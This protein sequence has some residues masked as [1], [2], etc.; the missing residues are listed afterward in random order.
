MCVCSAALFAGSPCGQTQKLLPPGKPRPQLQLLPHA[1]PVFVAY[2]R[3]AGFYL[4]ACVSGSR[5]A[6]C[7]AVAWDVRAANEERA[8]DL[9][10]YIA[11]EQAPALECNADSQ[12]CGMF[13]APGHVLLLWPEPTPLLTH[14]HHPTTCARPAPAVTWRRCRRPVHACRAPTGSATA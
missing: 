9:T 5:N 4:G 2:G 6:S 7:G 10:P 1:G 12:V 11:A 14:V 13:C 3:P 8:T